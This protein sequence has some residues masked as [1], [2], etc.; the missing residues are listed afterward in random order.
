[1]AQSLHPTNMMGKMGFPLSADLDRRDLFFLLLPPMLNLFLNVINGNNIKII[2][3]ISMLL[4][5]VFG[6][7]RLILNIL[8]F[9]T[10]S[11]WDRL[12]GIKFLLYHFFCRCLLYINEL[13][14]TNYLF[15]KRPF[16]ET[17]RNISV[18]KGLKPL[19][20]TV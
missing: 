9:C 16:F 1:M 5:L 6:C 17:K 12:L 3:K 15:Y 2:S 4:G 11:K 13:T 7:W 19:K 18:E 10:K 8:I 14:Q 20:L